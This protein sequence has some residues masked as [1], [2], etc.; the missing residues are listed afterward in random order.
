MQQDLDVTVD[1][2]SVEVKNIRKSTARYIAGFFLLDIIALFTIG[3]GFWVVVLSVLFVFS[4][5]YYVTVPT[6]LSR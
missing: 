6:R 2:N 1:N 3:I 5:Y 4:V